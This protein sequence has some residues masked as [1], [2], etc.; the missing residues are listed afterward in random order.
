MGDMGPDV[1]ALQSALQDLGYLPSTFAP[2]M[3]FGSLT[4]HALLLFQRDHQLNRSG[5]LDMQSQALLNRMAAQVS[6]RMG[7]KTATSTSSFSLTRY[8]T[9]GSRGADVIVLQKLLLKDGDYPEARITGY[10]GLLTQ[11]AVQRF[12]V[13]HG[14]VSS[15]SPTTTGYG[16]VGRRTRSVMNKL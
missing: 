6:V 14:I 10:F 12:Q 11:K 2:T 8:L 15:G 16:A 9:V 5:F 3:Y 13:K 4:Q 7:T 1:L